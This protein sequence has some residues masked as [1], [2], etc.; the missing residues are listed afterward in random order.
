MNDYIVIGSSGFLGS[1]CVKYLEFCGKK[2]FKSNARLENLSGLR[3]E[4]EDS[5][6]Y[7]VIC[8]AGLSGHPIIQY[9]EEHPNETR[10]VNY[11]GMINLMNLCRDR[12]LTIFG[13]GYIFTGSKSV[14]TENDEGDL[15]DFVYCRYKILLEKK[16]TPNVLYLRIMYPSSFDE[17]PRCFYNKTLERRGRLHDSRVSITSIPHLFPKL[18]ELIMGGA[19][20][21]YNFVIDGVISLKELVGDDSPISSD[22]PYGSYELSAEKL[23]MRISVIKNTELIDI[24]RCGC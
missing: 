11:E 3:K 14:Y 7:H 10:Q 8:A 6:A 17:H 5:G 12:H 22:K 4:I 19:T 16:L 2:V 1:N 18:D 15:T 23:K 24:V 9:C 20:G 21:I 13:S